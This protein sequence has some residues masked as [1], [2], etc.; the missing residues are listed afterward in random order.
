MRL[1]RRAAG[2]PGPAV[3][4][5][6]SRGA[7]RRRRSRAPGS[8]CGSPA[9]CRRLRRRWQRA[10]ADFDGELLAAR[11][12]VVA[13]E[14]VLTPEV[15]ELARAVADRYA[16]TLADVLR[17]AVPPRHAAVE[18]RARAEPSTPAS[19]LPGAARPAAGWARYPP[20][21]RFCARSRRTG[22]A[23]RGSWS[24]LPGEDWP[25]R[26]AEAVP[27]DL[28]GRARRAWSSCPTAATLDRLDA[29]L[30]RRARRRDGTSRS[31][32]TLGP[33]ERYRRVPAPPARRRC[34]VVVGTRAAMFAPVGRARPGRRLGRRRRPA[35]RAAR[36]LPARPRGAAS[37]APSWPSRRA[38]RRARP[39]RR[40]PAAGRVRLG[41]RARGRPARPAAG[42]GAAGRGRRRRPELARDPAAR[43]GPAAQPGLA[44]AR[45]ALEAGAPVLVQVPRRGY[46]PVAGLRPLP[47]AGPVRALRGPARPGWLGRRPLRR[48][49]GAPGRRR[50]R[51][52]GVRRAG[53]VRAVVAAPGAPPRSSAGP[54]PGSRCAPP[55]ASEVLDRR[56]RRSRPWWS[57]RPAPSR[58]P[59]GGYGAVLLLDAWALL[60][61]G[62]TCGP[63]RRRCAAG[64]PRPRWSGPAATAVRSWSSA[65]RPGSRRCRRWCA[66]TR[67]A[68]PSASWPSAGSSASRRPPG[69]RRSTGRPADVDATCSP[70][71]SCRP[72]RVLGPVP[73]SE[74]SSARWCGSRARTALRSLRALQAVTRVRSVRKEPV[75]RVRLDPRADR[76][77]PT[78]L[79]DC[80]SVAVQ[81]IRL[82]G[83]PVLRTPAAAGRRLRQGA[84]PARRRPHRHHAGR[85]RRRPRRAADR[86]RA[87]GLH[88]LR[89]RRGRPPGQPVLGPVARRAG[90]RRGLPVDPRAAVRLPARACGSSPRARTCTASRS[91]IEGTEL[92]ARALQH[93]TDHL[94]GVLFVD[95]LD[96]GAA[97]AGACRRSAR[98]SGS[99]Q[100]AA[101]GK[102][103]PHP[104]FGRALSRVRLVF[105]GTPA[106]ALPALEALLA[107]A[108]TS[109]SPWSP[110]PTPGRA[111]AAAGRLA[112]RASCAEAPASRCSSRGSPR[113]PDFLDRPARA[114]ARLLPGGGVRRAA[115]AGARSTS[116]AHGWVNLHFSLLPAWRGAAPVQHAIWPATTS[117]ARRRSGS[118]QG[119]DT[120]PVFGVVTEP[121]RPARHRRRPARRGSPEPARGCSSPRSTASPTA[122]S[123]RGR[124]RAT[125]SRWRPSSPSTT[126]VPTG[127]SRRS[128]S[129]GRSVPARRRRAPGRRS[130]AA[131][132]R[133]GRGRR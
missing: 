123:R 29:A 50:V 4:L 36:A 62:P 130:G 26:L 114:R 78:P 16:G 106:P 28:S 46:L 118:R 73:V 53:A 121:I 64:W 89:R 43:G 44:A 55:A 91:S 109:W 10:L 112:G 90:R 119:L 83:D 107:L 85:A 87:A 3:R 71:R 104:T 103:S 86:R 15:A 129:T 20:A 6:R 1:R 68:S 128:S 48:A 127:P 72:S 35:R 13:P 81:P 113:D 101:D 93:E 19:E 12:P 60:G 70:R 122:T 23:P 32:P 41:A 51:L 31:R 14:P 116:R 49:A 117:P 133:P 100:R 84:A 77:R 56:P 21:R 8:G 18:K 58:S 11:A 76:L 132:A 66:G 125:A 110:V 65:R 39:H 94:D 2:P 120:G 74:E 33:A 82:F 5:R 115:A 7:G 30:D 63:A 111:A 95:R 99:A 27:R 79:L 42:R 61:P 88:L 54:S 17:L 124:S 126:R 24:A 52:P 47:H 38:G 97:Q 102:V 34:T 59:T 25:A 131:E 45:A 69:S 37:C 108:G 75:V 98:P 57:P 105:A 40:G 80:P 9:S 96:P 67:L 92:L 22:S